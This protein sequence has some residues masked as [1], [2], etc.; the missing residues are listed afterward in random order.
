MGRLLLCQPVLA[1][2][3]PKCHCKQGQNPPSHS[4]KHCHDCQ[5]T[6]FLHPPT[7]EIIFE[8]LSHE[9][10]KSYRE[11]GTAK[12]SHIFAR[13]L[14]TKKETKRTNFF[15]FGEIISSISRHNARCVGR[16]QAHVLSATGE[17]FDLDLDSSRHSTLATDGW[18]AQAGAAACLGSCC[19]QTGCL[20]SLQHQS[21]K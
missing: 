10:T 18:A 2:A 8:E 15:T 4:P 20:L 11:W 17:Y 12:N 19:R 5:V 6:V 3:T 1:S 21:H 9:V 7:L 16:A 14:V 13:S